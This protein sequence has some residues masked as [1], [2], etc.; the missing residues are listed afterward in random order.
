MVWNADDIDRA[1]PVL[2][3]LDHGGDLGRLGHVGARVEHLDAELGLDPGAQ[4]FD[5]AG[6]AETVE[7]DA[8]AGLGE[9]ARDAEPDPRGG[10]GDDCVFSLKHLESLVNYRGA[11]CA[12]TGVL[13]C[14]AKVAI[15]L[16]HCNIF[17]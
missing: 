7:H 12:A 15:V 4:L 9:G 10:P 13:L 14:Q 2:R 17:L 11:G 5:L 6:L 1:E 8:G 3:G 16:L